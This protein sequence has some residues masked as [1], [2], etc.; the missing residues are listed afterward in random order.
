L[1]THLL[2]GTWFAFKYTLRNKAIKLERTNLNYGAMARL[3]RD[4]GFIIVL[5]I[6][7][8]AIPAHFSTA[9]F[10]T[11]DVKFWFFVVATLLSLPKQIFLVYLGVLLVQDSSDSVVKTLM[12]GAVFIITVAMGVWIWLKMRAIKKVLLEEQEQR[13]VKSAQQMQMQV[14]SPGD[15]K[16][17]GRLRY[18]E[19]AAP[20]WNARPTQPTQMV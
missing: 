6:R 12:F 4:G 14:Q 13:R 1:L 19:E 17:P 9:V 11:C 15:V 18:E 3:T 16:G 2:V 5:V 7:L 20:E 8:S 10:S